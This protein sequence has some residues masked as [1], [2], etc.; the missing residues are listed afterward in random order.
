MFL[1]K[2]RAEDGTLGFIIDLVLA[3]KKIDTECLSSMMNVVRDNFNW[4][5]RL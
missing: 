2:R 1:I 3:I 4:Y 5:G